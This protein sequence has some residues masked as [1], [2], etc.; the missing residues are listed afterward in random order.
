MKQRNLIILILITSL[1]FSACQKEISDES[2]I[3]SST[4]SLVWN[5]TKSPTDTRQL[6]DGL[7]PAI[8][9]K[10]FDNA[11][12]ANITITTNYIRIP[13]NCFIRKDNSAVTGNVVLK[14]TNA[15]KFDEMI[16]L[17]LATV[18]STEL[19][20][21]NGMVKILALQN[22]DTLKVSPSKSISVY[23]KNTTGTTYQPFIGIQNNSVIN[24][25]TWNLSNNWTASN[26]TLG[27]TNTG[28]LYTRIEVDSC[29]WINCDQFVNQPNPTNI[30][31]KLPSD[32]GNANTICYMVFKTEKIIT[33]MYADVANKQY[34]QG[35]NYKVPEGKNVKLIAICKKD[36]KTY[37]GIVETVIT[38]NA[39][40]TIT[41]MTEVTELEL[42]NKLSAL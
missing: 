20:S 35:P 32:F 38:A 5:A 3:G 6:L 17:N 13:A 26:D 37:Y 25:I 8:T 22:G 2:G 21:T 10:S 41:T 30:Y 28:G 23:F 1:I 40:N 36:N 39:T 16:Y 14:I 42:K 34:S 31:L 24:N 19:L 4:T 29:T 7:K 9:E 12:G 33:G 15:T 11:V 27:G 18:T